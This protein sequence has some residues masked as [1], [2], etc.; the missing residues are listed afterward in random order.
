MAGPYRRC[1]NLRGSQYQN[2]ALDS[3]ELA[4]ASAA[5]S[6][7]LLLL[8]PS[9]SVSNAPLHSG[10]VLRLTTLIQRLTARLCSAQVPPGR[11]C[12]IR[13]RRLP[14]ESQSHI[15][16]RDALERHIGYH[17]LRQAILLLICE[18]TA[19]RHSKG[20][21]AN[22]SSGWRCIQNSPGYE[23]RTR[24]RSRARNAGNWHRTEA[25]I[26]L[27]LRE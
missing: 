21:L 10:L 8:F 4:D 9:T 20:M 11:H 3:L 27:L 15:S 24:T 14:R 19:L 26:W 12:Q 23:A 17:S 2:G 16:D 7:C 5:E 25:R 18:H 22:A 13:R 1:H 6:C